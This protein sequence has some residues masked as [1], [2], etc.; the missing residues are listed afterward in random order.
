MVNK[1]K[2]FKISV[3]VP[4]HNNGLRFYYKGFQSLRRSTYFDKIEI[5]VVD[6]VSE[7]NS[8]DLVES[9]QKQF[10]NIKLYKLKG[11]P[12]GS[13]SL[14]RNIGLEKA[15]AN[16]VIFFDPDDEVLPTG[17]QKL[18]EKMEKTGSSLVFGNNLLYGYE[19]LTHDVF[20]KY[21]RISRKDFFEKGIKYILPKADFFPPCL[22]T[23]LFDKHILNKYDVEKFIK[24]AFAEDTLFVWSL[25]VLPIPMAMVKDTVYLYYNKVSSSVTNNI[26]LNF[27]E[28]SKRSAEGIL[29]WLLKNDLHQEYFKNRFNDY[30]TK[31][32]LPKLSY[33]G[34]DQKKLACLEALK[35]ISIL[36]NSKK[37]T[38]PNILLFLQKCESGLYDEAIDLVTMEPYQI[39]NF[40]IRNRPPIKKDSLS[41]DDIYRKLIILSNK[42]TIERKY[43]YYKL[44]RK[45]F[46]FKNNKRLERRF[47]K[48]KKLHREL[49]EIKKMLPFI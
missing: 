33:V 9:L 43:I 25:L 49:S 48:Y 5:V 32:I 11:K 45:I 47:D 14:P 29:R 4:M 13:A 40:G 38:N 34:Y 6:D 1:M 42:T 23:I 12:S 41:S 17:Y 46:V 3:I 22:P 2:D 35:I 19:C 31:W 18:Y 10:D 30:I 16:H 15:S 26:S 21:Y 24:G 7:D 37:I 20:E 39:R 36:S 8:V 27:F 28:S 44:I